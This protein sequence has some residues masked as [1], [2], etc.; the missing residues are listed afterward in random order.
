[1]NKNGKKKLI[2]VW[3]WWLTPVT[4]A[5]WEAKA[6]ESPEVRNSRPAWT[7]WQNPMSTK[8]SKLSQAW[9]QAPIVPATPE[10]QESLIPRGGGCS[11]TGSCHCTPAWVTRAKLRL[12]INK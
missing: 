8:N 9:W 7:T 4:P 1:M 3:A 5:L 6:D 10:A 2:R 11:E 12:K